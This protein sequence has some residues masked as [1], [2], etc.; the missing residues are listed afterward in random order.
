MG[1]TSRVRCPS[2]SSAQVPD[3]HGD[4]RLLT[5]PVLEAVARGAGAERQRG[6]MSG[7]GTNWGQP[8]FPV[9]ASA[10]ASSVAVSRAVPP[11]FLMKE[12]IITVVKSCN[13][14][15]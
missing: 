12:I 5:L 10:A 8:G 13:A 3:P 1:G 15:G 11:P 14:G 4:R 6:L 2:A 9:P 7:C